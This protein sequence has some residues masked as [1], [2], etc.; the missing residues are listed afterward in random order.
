MA[1]VTRTPQYYLR[2][3][4]GG[5]VPSGE[6]LKQLESGLVTVQPSG[7]TPLGNRGRTS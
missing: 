6:S 2:P 5:D 7:K 4:G 1:G 3:Q